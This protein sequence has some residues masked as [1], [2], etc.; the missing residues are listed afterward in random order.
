MAATNEAIELVGEQVERFVSIVAG[1]AGD[2]IGAADLNVPL[3]DEFSV[4]GVG[5]DSAGLLGGGSDFRSIR[6]QDSEAFSG[7]QRRFNQRFLFNAALNQSSLTGLLDLGAG[8]APPEWLRLC[9]E[10]RRGPVA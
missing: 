2:Q 7:A 3:G 1:L 8:D 9:G 10:L 5:L 4:L 6:N